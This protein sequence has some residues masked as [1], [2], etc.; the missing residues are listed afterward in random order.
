MGI[1][2]VEID[3]SGLV[4]TPSAEGLLE[5]KR[6]ILHDTTLRQW[7]YPLV[8]VIVVVKESPMPFAETIV[9]QD[10]SPQPP[11]RTRYTILGLWVDVR[12]LEY[13]SVVVKSVAYSPLIVDLL[14]RLA[15][16]YSGRYV[17]KYKNWMFPSWSRALLQQEL[18]ALADSGQLVSGGH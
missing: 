8:P 12:V 3:L 1:R 9:E 11:E 7:L 17:A 5:L 16:Q 13:G 2:T 18:E 15:R 14:K 4:V 6:A 10:P